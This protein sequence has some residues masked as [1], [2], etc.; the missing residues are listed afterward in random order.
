LKILHK[1]GITSLSDD[2]V[3]LAKFDSTGIGYSPDSNILHP[4]ELMDDMKF[5]FSMLSKKI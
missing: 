1:T 4:L 3:L 2:K 5:V